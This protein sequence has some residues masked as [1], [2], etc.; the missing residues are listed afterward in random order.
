[1]DED[2]AERTYKVLEEMRQLGE[3]EMPD[4]STSPFAGNGDSS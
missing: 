3:L 4:L 1:V 2:E